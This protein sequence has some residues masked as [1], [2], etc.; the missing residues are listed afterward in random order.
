VL[1][2]DVVCYQ[3]EAVALVAADHPETARQAAK[4]I[5]V[6]YQVWEPVTDPRAAL[7]HPSWNRL[8]DE[9]PD[10]VGLSRS[11]APIHPRGNLLPHLKIRKGRGS[12]TT[13]RPG[14]GSRPPRG[15]RSW[16]CTRRPPRWVRG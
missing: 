2:H 5:R 10:T 13:P 7:G 3:G 9:N 15:S 11:A 14:S 16:S 12:T 8:H 6:D 1:A 4:R